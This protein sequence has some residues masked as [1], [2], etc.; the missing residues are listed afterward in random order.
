[1]ASP[2]SRLSGGFR[3]IRKGAYELYIHPQI[4]WDMGVKTG[5]DWTQPKTGSHKLLGTLGRVL[6]TPE[7]KWFW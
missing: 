7:S 4:I 1:M 3:L 2:H 6:D 5:I